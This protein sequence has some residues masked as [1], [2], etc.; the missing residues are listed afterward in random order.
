MKRLWLTLACALPL[1]G[2]SLANAGGIWC[3]TYDAYPR[4]Q[5]AIVHGDFDRAREAAGGLASTLGSAL[6]QGDVPENLVKSVEIMAEAASELASVSRRVTW[7][8]VYRKCPELR[9]TKAPITKEMLSKCGHVDEATQITRAFARLSFGFF[10]FLRVDGRLARFDV[11][12][13]VETG[14]LW[15]QPA[16]EAFYNPYAGSKK[17]E[18]ATHVNARRE[19]PSE[20]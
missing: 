17:P 7:K 20:E 3:A 1:F 16:G 14:H 12:K 6:K 10:Q 18:S 19:R 15:V 9:R 11:Y 5:N 2:G 8:R 4:I 13:D